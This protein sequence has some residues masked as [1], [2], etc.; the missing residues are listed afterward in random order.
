M[1]AFV[2]VTSGRVLSGIAVV[3]SVVVGI[4]VVITSGVV[5]VGFF[6]VVTSVAGVCVAAVVGDV[7]VVGLMEL[8]EVL[9]LV[10]FIVASLLVVLDEELRL[11]VSSRGVD[12]VDGADDVMFS[13]PLAENS[14]KTRVKAPKVFFILTVC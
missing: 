2:A 1:G 7:V 14:S 9:S 8:T 6:V 13:S 3:T 10:V 12:V 4:V 5:V 11:V